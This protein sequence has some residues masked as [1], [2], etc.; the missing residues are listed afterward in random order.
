M[1]SSTASAARSRHTCSGTT[2]SS[3][4]RRTT[5]TTPRALL[6]A[7]LERAKVRHG[8]DAPIVKTLQ[9]QLDG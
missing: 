3:W 2:R 6:Q 4:A 9:Q 7:A 8:S 5:T 1:S